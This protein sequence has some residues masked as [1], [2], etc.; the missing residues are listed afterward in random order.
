MRVVR[1]FSQGC[2]TSKLPIALRLATGFSPE[3]V[4]APRMPAFDA[5]G[6]VRHE[7]CF[8]RDHAGR[9]FERR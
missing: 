7:A 5:P 6:E 2:P 9:A 4:Q 8:R 1:D 3:P